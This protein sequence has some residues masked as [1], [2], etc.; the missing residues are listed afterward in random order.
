MPKQNIGRKG[1]SEK[2]NT[3][4]EDSLDEA[5]DPIDADEIAPTNAET[6]RAADAPKNEAATER[7]D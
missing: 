5:V 2:P 3:N 1:M 7:P 4:A 6:S